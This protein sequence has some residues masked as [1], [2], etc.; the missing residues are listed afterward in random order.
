MP[1]AG[2][3]AKPSRLVRPATLMVFSGAVTV[4]FLGLLPTEQQLRA[5]AENAQAG[6]LSAIYLRLLVR[7]N[8]HD[9]ALGRTLARSLSAAGKYDEARAILESM[10]ALPG[11][12]GDEAR[13]AILTMDYAQAQML[14]VGDPRRAELVSG[15]GAQLEVARELPLGAAVLVEL[16]ELGLAVGRR[17]LANVFFEK[18]IAA[19]A[20]NEA[21][22]RDRAGRAL[23]ALLAHGMGQ[24]A[25]ALAGVAIHF[26]GD[27][28]EF[29][30]RGV[31]IALSQNDH[32]RAQ[33]WGRRLLAM[34]PDDV[35]TL[36]RQLQMELATSNLAAAVALARRLVELEPGNDERRVQL[37]R[38]AQ[39]DGRPELALE[40][41]S[42]LA[43]DDPQG[44]AMSVALGLAQGLEAHGRWVELAARLAQTRALAPGELDA[45][46]YLHAT[47]RSPLALVDFLEQYLLRHPAHR[48][49]WR[50]LA[51]THERLRDFDAAARTWERMTPRLVAPVESAVRQA[52]LLRAAARPEQALARLRLAEGQA[53]R[54]DSAYWRLRGDLAWEQSSPV[55]A[56]HAYEL[57]RGA[58]GGD[59]LVA[60]RLIHSYHERGEPALAIAMAKQAYERRGEERWLLLAMD[61]AAQALLWSELRSLADS[62]QREEHRFAESE[63]Y[64]LLQAHLAKHERR[65]E[66]A[67]RAYDAALKVNPSSPSARIGALW[68]GIE[69]DD[70]QRLAQHLDQWRQ[71]AALEPSYWAPFAVGLLSLGRVSESLPWFGRRAQQRPDDLLWL[72]SYA[73]ALARA[74]KPT[75]SRRLRAH[76]HAALQRRV[77]RA[78]G[79]GGGP[80]DQLLLTHAALVQEFEGARA[81]EQLLRALLLQGADDAAVREMAIASHLARGE[82]E[83]ARRWLPHTDGERKQPPPWQRLALAL[84]QDDKAAIAQVLAEGGEELSAQDRV[85]ALR[86]TGRD[87]EALVLAQR[88]V[89]ERDGP[90]ARALQGHIDEL[91]ALRA[92]ALAVQHDARRL[93]ELRISRTQVSGSVAV[94]GGRAGAQLDF[95]QLRAN[96]DE[97]ADVGD[98]H[99][100]SVQYEHPVG[101]GRMRVVVGTNQRADDPVA[102]GRYEWTAPL[103]TDTTARLDLS[104]NGVTDES[105]ALRAVGTR[106]RLAGAI[107]VQLTD[108]ESARAEVAAQRFQTR[109][110]HVLGKGYRIDAEV[111]STLSREAPLWQLR[112]QGSVQKNDV[113]DTLP[114]GL[115]RTVLSPAME[116]ES[117]LADRYA[118]LGA[119]TTLRIGP[120]HGST[121]QSF[122]QLDA[123][124]GK[125]WPDARAAYH[126]RVT[127]GTPIHRD[128]TLGIDAFY[129][130]TQGGSA[131]EAYRGVGVFYTHRF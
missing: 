108:T 46:A 50:M 110:G 29:L 66:D 52:A 63:M 76:L 19:S 64:W 27:E 75:Q 7:F 78:D 86:R 68:L 131:G 45:L 12:D 44:E 117:V 80:D 42:R 122:A 20:G 16:G 70:R 41:W 36:A 105:A 84:A 95:N 91:A 4:A 101:E 58:N 2:H 104:V 90:A 48:E 34:A 88:T 6:P 126:L 25:L 102:Y 32:D 62:A 119:G 28:R 1:R 59:A 92:S 69:R 83:A 53:T 79:E 111:G 60:E 82:Y 77:G 96:G 8:P 99:D 9:V 113:R 26:L 40:H 49:A 35:G 55:E 54:S 56:A 118:T 21:E 22:L 94:D 115:A 3:D 112:L 124:V 37:A 23:R 120:A 103:W 128:G 13:L 39:W 123:W 33:A 67:Q 129:T 18:A 11:A 10:V 114:A 51:E 31:E 130:N 47:R 73:H 38:L 30:A 85:A 81:G 127:S 97:L 15:V 89:A 106:D 125:V 93:G 17:E 61:A 100:V 71:D 121:R 98:E 5:M 43:F 74:G 65:A 57:V 87:E 107:A 72:S 109:D 116:M 14:P 24:E